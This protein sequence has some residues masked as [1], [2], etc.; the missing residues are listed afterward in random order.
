M[1]M[2]PRE[3]FDRVDIFGTGNRKELPELAKPG[4]YV[5]Y[6][7]DKPYYVGQAKKTMRGRIG[8]HATVPTERHYHLWN[9]FSAFVI[10]DPTHRS[11][12]EA[13]LIAA[14]PTANSA[15]P[16]L[17]K[18]KTSEKVRKLFHELRT[19]KAFAPPNRAQ[20]KS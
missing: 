9:Y 2:W 13:I 18:E 1:R 8:Q 10:E 4:V 14:M 15:R 12:V 11:D 20:T 19:K 5:L 6:R 7:D 17:P 16:K 3:I